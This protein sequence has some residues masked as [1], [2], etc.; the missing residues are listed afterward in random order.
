MSVWSHLILCD[1]QKQV[2]WQPARQCRQ[3][4]HQL[5]IK[6]QIS[7]VHILRGKRMKSRLTFNHPHNR[8][9]FDLVCR[10]TIWTNLKPSIYFTLD[11]EC[12]KRYYSNTTYEELEEQTVQSLGYRVD[13]LGSFFSKD[14]DSYFF[15]TISRQVLR[16]IHP[17]LQ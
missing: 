2:A 6:V 10:I 12:A 11:S 17:P 7:S 5:P 16:P 15:F 1:V 13:I 8:L 3:C 9:I 4:Y 14:I